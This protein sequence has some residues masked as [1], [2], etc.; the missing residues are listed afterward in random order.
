VKEEVGVD[1]E[2]D[3]TR[4]SHARIRIVRLRFGSLVCGNLR[5]F[6]GMAIGTE[7]G[8]SQDED[9]DVGNVSLNWASRGLGMNQVGTEGGGEKGELERTG[10]WKSKRVGP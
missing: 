1:G 5:R 3:A 8:R 10:E 6:D 4:R 7:S 9:D 2:D